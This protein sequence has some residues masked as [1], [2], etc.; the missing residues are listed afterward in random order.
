VKVVFLGTSGTFP[1]IGRNVTSHGIWVKGETLL[2]DCGEGTQRQLRRT[3]LRF[4]AH[5]I[6]LSHM[7][8][9]HILG[10][11][12]YVWS[13]DLLGRTEPLSIYVPSRA[14]RMIEAM[15][16]GVGKLSYPVQIQELDDG[17]VVSLPG[18][19]V[20]A[21]KVEH[22]GHCCLGFRVEEETRVG[23]VDID[24]ARELGITPGPNIGKLTR[25]ESIELNGVIITPEQ[26]VGPTRRGRVVVYSGDT[27]PCN[28]MR[29]L[30]RDAD[31]L[32]HEASFTNAM[33]EEARSR[34]HSTAQGAATVAAEAHVKRLALT[35]ISQRH[36][37]EEGIRTLLTEARQVFPH[38]FLPYDLDEVELA[39]PD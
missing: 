32:L 27:R 7:H 38:S 9:D 19:K 39:L 30:A 5:R 23:K 15:I 6:F 22:S 12:G 24:K 35:H 33:L 2:L 37:D 11:P 4:F 1:T 17:A 28:A 8:G 10:L 25:G 16:G 18:Y 34:A 14:K 29:Q 21:A 20:I 13:M 36:Q 31:L 3:S 26:V